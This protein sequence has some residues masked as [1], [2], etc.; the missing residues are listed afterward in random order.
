VS[1]VIWAVA[2]YRSNRPAELVVTDAG[3]RPESIT[4][5]HAGR[6]PSTRA[7]TTTP[8]AAAPGASWTETAEGT[9]VIAVYRNADPPAGP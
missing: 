1:G 6:A 5:Q 4:Y 8:W 9:W 3:G 7:L 2:E